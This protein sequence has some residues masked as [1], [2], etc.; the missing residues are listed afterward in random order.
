[1]ER[2]ETK[3]K[4]QNA[5]H[6]HTISTE[7]MQTTLKLALNCVAQ[8]YLLSHRIR[9]NPNPNTNTFHTRQ[10]KSVEEKNK[11]KK[12]KKKKKVKRINRSV[13][14]SNSSGL[15][16][17]MNIYLSNSVQMKTDSHKRCAPFTIVYSQMIALCICMDFVI[18]MRLV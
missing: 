7:A 3:C 9:R 17:C 5:K 1:M 18:C 4:I 13:T 11:Q 16:L 2:K 14:H 10:E 12:M 6:A 8:K 15:T